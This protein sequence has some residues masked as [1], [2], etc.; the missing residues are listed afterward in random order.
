MWERIK[1]FF[2][3]SETIFWARLQ[4][5]LGVVATIVTYVDP[6]VLAPIM[7]AE[8]APL[9]LVAHGIALEYLRRRRDE[10]M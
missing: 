7:P 9:L 4:V 10:E 2:L 1:A 5:F 6:S 3:D 8:W